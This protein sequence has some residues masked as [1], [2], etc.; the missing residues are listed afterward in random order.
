MTEQ[1]LQFAKEGNLER[2]KRLINEEGADVNYQ[3]KAG[4]TALMFASRWG[5][6]EI[7]KLLI[8]KRAKLDLQNKE[9]ETALDIARR[10]NRHEI[11]ELLATS[12]A[13]SFKNLSLADYD[14]KLS[15]TN[16]KSKWCRL[17]NYFIKKI[18]TN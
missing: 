17:K 8:E 14:D 13:T 1:L 16:K 18:T 5:Y 6:F 7:V 9:G 10:L 15:G 3:N 4:D 11:V 12:F 2:V